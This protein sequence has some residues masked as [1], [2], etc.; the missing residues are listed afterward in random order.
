MLHMTAAY[1]TDWVFPEL[2]PGWPWYDE[3]P[4]PVPPP[5]RMGPGF[6]PE[7]GLTALLDLLTDLWAK[8]AVDRARLGLH[9]QESDNSGPTRRGRRR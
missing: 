1:A 5:H 2:P 8:E 9:S 7:R 3:D 6:D 4:E